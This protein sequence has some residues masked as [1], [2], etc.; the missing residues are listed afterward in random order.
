MY[1]YDRAG[2]DVCWKRQRSLGF[3]SIRCAA[4]GQTPDSLCPLVLMCTEVWIFSGMNPLGS[5][6]RSTKARPLAHVPQLLVC[7]ASAFGFMLAQLT[8]WKS[9]AVRVVHLGIRKSLE[10][11]KGVSQLHHL[12]GAWCHRDEREQRLSGL[13]WHMYRS[14][15]GGAYQTFF[16]FSFSLSPC[17][18]YFGVGK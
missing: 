14:S 7:R 10:K 9:L 16:F 12:R 1:V 4:K 15:C 2:D 11:R 6:G 8:V 13:T 17:W 18:I 5:N 3:D